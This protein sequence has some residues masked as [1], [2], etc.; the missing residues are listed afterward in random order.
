MVVREMPTVPKES[1]CPFILLPI[2]GSGLPELK[3]SRLNAPRILQVHK[4]YAYC[5]ARLRDVGLEFAIKEP[6]KLQGLKV[7]SNPLLLSS[8]EPSL[9]IFLPTLMYCT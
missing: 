1:K 4:V 6:K 2:E 9:L 3:T 8:P 5:Q 7:R